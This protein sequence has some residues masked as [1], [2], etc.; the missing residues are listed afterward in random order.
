MPDHPF[1]VVGK[2]VYLRGRTNSAAPF[3]LPSALRRAI[4]TGEP[5]AASPAYEM[6]TE[7]RREHAWLEGP[8]TP[9]IRGG[10]SKDNELV[11]IQWESAP[12]D[13]ITGR[14]LGPAGAVDLFKLLDGTWIGRVDAWIPA[15]PEGGVRHWVEYRRV[16]PFLLPGDA[17]SVG[18]RLARL[19]GAD[20]RA[21]RGGW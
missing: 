16:D 17:A 12:V 1:S 6:G 14:R 10:W 21:G 8:L 15:G 2:V 5:V 19:M 7:S 20:L 4:D 18:G 13:F 9:D 3:G 11:A